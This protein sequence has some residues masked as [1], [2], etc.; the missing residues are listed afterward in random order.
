M[1]AGELHIDGS[2]SET[3]LD[4]TYHYSEKIS[5]SSGGV[6]GAHGQLTIESPKKS[7]SVTRQR[8]SGIYG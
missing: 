1:G 8:T 6:T 4:A 2:A 5:A 7:Q 3:F